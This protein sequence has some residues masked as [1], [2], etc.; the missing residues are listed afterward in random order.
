MSTSSFIFAK[1]PVILMIC[2]ITS[3]FWVVI[4]AR[5][6]WTF[7][8]GITVFRYLQQ[9]RW[10]HFGNISLLSLSVILTTR[11]Y[12]TEY[13]LQVYICIYIPPVMILTSLLTILTIKEA[14]RT[15]KTY[16]S[17]RLTPVSVIAY[18][19]LGYMFCFTTGIY[20]LSS[21]QINPVISDM[22]MSFLSRL[23]IMLPVTLAEIAVIYLLLLALHFPDGVSARG[24]SVTRY[25][26]HNDWFYY[27]NTGNAILALILSTWIYHSSISLPAAL[28]TGALSIF[29]TRPFRPAYRSL[30]TRHLIQIQ[31]YGIHEK[32]PRQQSFIAREQVTSLVLS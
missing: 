25:L 19:G 23:S 1:L 14:T 16:K 29:L 11:V 10:F 5:G 9:Y 20:E 3:L 4:Y 6:K 17:N 28:F 30:N 26:R 32:H 12:D 22:L 7:F 8:S 13:P 24:F 31:R 27:I 15:Y 2:I 18:A 21:T